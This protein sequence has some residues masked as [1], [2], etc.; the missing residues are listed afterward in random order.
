M[1]TEMSSD[2][3]MNINP[4]YD[5]SKEKPH[6]EHQ[7]DYVTHNQ[8]DNNHDNIK[9]DTNPSYAGDQCANNDIAIQENPSYE[10][11]Q[12]AHSARDEN[13]DVCITHE[14]EHVKMVG[15]ITKE[16]ETEYDEIDDVNI[17]PNPSYDSMSGGVKLEDN[18]SYS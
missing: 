16:D 6:Q 15:S 9:M 14:A 12:G 8:L 18:P 13:E 5:I 2:I 11:F 3:E 10:I 7:Y 17:T 1:V 4:S